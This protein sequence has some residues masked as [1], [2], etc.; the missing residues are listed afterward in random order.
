MNKT[1]LSKQ[2]DYMNKIAKEV[3]KFTFTK[4]HFNTYFLYN[5]KT[6]GM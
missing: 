1:C 3:I 6:N 2:L 4:Q 5:I